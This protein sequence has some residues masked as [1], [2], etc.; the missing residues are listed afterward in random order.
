[1][2]KEWDPDDIFDVLAS[3]TAREI[4]VAAHQGPVSASDLVERCGRSKATVYRRLSQLEEYGLLTTELAVDGQGNHFSTYETDM[5][6]ICFAISGETFE[7][8]VARRP[9]FV[10]RFDA[11]WRSL[12]RG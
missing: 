11:L 3:E 7:A 10:D 5:D 1:M 2:S 8:T 12:E 9:G 4:L 6:E